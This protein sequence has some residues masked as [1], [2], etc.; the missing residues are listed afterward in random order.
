[1]FKCIQ[2]NWRVVVA[3][4][5]LLAAV[6]VYLFTRIYPPQLL[7]PLKALNTELAAFTGI[8]GSAPSFFYTLALGLI[9]GV[10]ASSR[11][12][13]KIHCLIWIVLAILLELSQARII[14]EQI[15]AWL[16]KLLPQSIWAITGPYWTR[17]VFDPLDLLATF[18]GG[19][20]VLILLAYLPL[21][22]G[23]V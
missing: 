5:S 6:A 11:L 20:F 9:I 22:K 14:S 1:M 23:E 21:E 2:F 8:F 19:C 18:I 17:G 4:A 7:A 12:G 10:F 16:S 13:A 3:G 15:I